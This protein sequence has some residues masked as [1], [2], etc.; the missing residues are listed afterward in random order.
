VRKASSEQ[1]TSAGQIHR[2]PIGGAA[3][4]APPRSA[5]RRQLDDRQGDRRV[6]RDDRNLNRAISEQATASGEVSTP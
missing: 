2:P 1:A 6:E 3:P 4:S 5:N